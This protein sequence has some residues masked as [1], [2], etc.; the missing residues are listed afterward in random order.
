MSDDYSF[1]EISKIISL[2]KENG[3]VTVEQVIDILPNELS[4][5]DKL[6]EICGIIDDNNIELISKN[7][8]HSK[9]KMYQDE[10]KDET[11]E[12]A[13][14][15]AVKNVGHD[16]LRMYFKEMGK[17]PLLTREGEVE[18]AKRIEKAKIELQGSLCECMLVLD[19]L[20]MMAKK[21][22]Q[23][24]S[25]IT[26][27][28]K[29]SSEIEDEEEIDELEERTESILEKD[30]TEEKSITCLMADEFLEKVDKI[31]KIFHRLKPLLERAMKNTSLNSKDKETITK[32][33]K[34]IQ[35]IFV[36]IPFTDNSIEA[37]TNIIRE[38]NG[39]FIAANN[40][41]TAIESRLG[42][43]FNKYKQYVRSFNPSLQGDNTQINVAKY[44]DI[45]TLEKKIRNARRK[46]RR[47]ELDGYLAESSVRRILITIE[48]SNEHAEEAKAK[49]VQAN[50][51]LVVSLAKK[52]TNRG[53]HFTDLI[54][55]GNIGLM[56][57]VD[58]FEYR[59]GYKF[60]TYA[61]WW[62]RQAITR[63]IADQ[64]RTIRI[65]VHMIE[66]INKLLKISRKLVQENGREPR[67]EEIA[68]KMDLPVIKVRKI[69]KI[70]QEPIS[71]ETPIGEEE[72]SH[73]GDFIEDQKAINPEKLVIMNNLE[74]IMDSLLK[75]LTFREELVIRKRF[76]I[77][78]E[79]EST[80][81][82]VGKEF[83]VTRERIRQIESKALRKLK[84]PSRSK[85]LKPFQTIK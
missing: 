37:F 33:Q 68:E 57:A 27:I 75:T 24:N 30:E 18:L 40:C 47:V 50:L 6:S 71:L 3:Y 4:T 76:G 38:L 61:T 19:E 22:K 66:T 31:K 32:Y 63:S 79:T 2:G 15:P 42:M 45:D 52:Y 67:Y 64:S 84:H 54:Q 56:K 28:I 11:I 16:P 78:N 48:T 21:L 53:L 51:R 25:K 12:A 5:P 65:P 20:F 59:R 44:E 72:D 85:K 83:A 14:L 70:A 9:T 39:R 62:I 73:L 41:I 8:E 74:K 49:L 46:K 17:V 29:N 43:P 77:S 55:E 81:E 58:K 82:D 35:Q 69:L 34:Q 26:D 36:D 60:S 1:K 13:K 10:E 23:G 7:Q 80:L